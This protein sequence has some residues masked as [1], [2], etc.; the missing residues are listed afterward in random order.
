MTPSTPPAGS[1][2]LPGEDHPVVKRLDAD[3]H[4]GRRGRARRLSAPRAR[5]QPGGRTGSRSGH[6]P[7]HQRA[8]GAVI[9]QP[10]DTVVRSAA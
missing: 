2:L 3:R 5:S 7:G 6:C 4:L 9:R 1:H 10:C 8:T